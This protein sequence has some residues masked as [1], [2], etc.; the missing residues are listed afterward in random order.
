MSNGQWVGG[1][2]LYLAR[3]PPHGGLSAPPRR[4]VIHVGSKQRLESPVMSGC[5][6][7]TLR[8]RVQT[9]DTCAGFAR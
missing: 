6:T 1:R 4:A 7:C 5:G 8:W 2:G 3:L 9:A